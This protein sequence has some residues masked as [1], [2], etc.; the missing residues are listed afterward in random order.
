MKSLNINLTLKCEAWMA[1]THILLTFLLTLML[2]C[3]CIFNFSTPV[4]SLQ[5]DMLIITQRNLNHQ[6]ERS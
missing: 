2:T 4:Y 5:I 3:L 1:L 6:I